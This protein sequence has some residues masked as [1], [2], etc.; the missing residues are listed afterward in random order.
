MTLVVADSRGST[1]PEALQQQQGADP[2]ASQGAVAEATATQ[3]TATDQQ[4]HV[5]ALRAHLEELQAALR[6]G[7]TTAYRHAR[8]NARNSERCTSPGS[9][10]QQ[11]LRRHNASSLCAIHSRPTGSGASCL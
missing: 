3:A 9:G 7:N 10:G 6:A 2:T 11:G 5:V 4:A 1:V 8:A